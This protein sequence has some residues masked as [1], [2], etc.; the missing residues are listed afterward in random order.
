MEYS[1]EIVGVSSVIAFLDG[2]FAQQFARLDSQDRPNGQLGAAYL[3]TSECTLDALIASVETMPLRQGWHLDRIVDSVIAFWLNNAEP[4][5]R[6]R[7]RLEDAGTQSLLIARV[8]DLEALR[9]EFEGLL[10]RD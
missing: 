3:G 4:V 2:H 6:W 5:H 10:G 8:A 7:R 1:F 9:V